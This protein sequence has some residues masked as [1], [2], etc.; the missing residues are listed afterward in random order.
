MVFFEKLIN[1][2]KKSERELLRVKIFL[3]SITFY[4]EV[5][6]IDLQVKI[7][8]VFHIWRDINLMSDYKKLQEKPPE[9]HKA[10]STLTSEQLEEMKTSESGLTSGEARIRLERDGPNALPEVKVNPFLKFLSY[11]WGPMPA[12]IWSAIII[13]LARLA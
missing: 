8:E 12:M 7:V 10:P 2:F 11:Y 3:L 1:S 6:V 9:E 4:D 5:L 13:E